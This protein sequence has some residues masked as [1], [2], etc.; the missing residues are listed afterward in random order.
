MSRLV[1]QSWSNMRSHWSQPSMS[2]Q[3]TDCHQ[4]HQYGQGYRRPW[5][6]EYDI[7]EEWTCQWQHCRAVNNEQLIAATRTQG[8]GTTWR[9]MGLHKPWTRESSRHAATVDS[10]H[11]QLNICCTSAQSHGLQFDTDSPTGRSHWLDIALE[12]VIQN[13]K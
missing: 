13:K 3:H 7:V 5:A 11:R 4:N 8:P 2:A 6:E 10:N 9:Q 12:Q 1:I